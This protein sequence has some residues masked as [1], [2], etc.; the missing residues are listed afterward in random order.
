MRAPETAEYVLPAGIY[1]IGDPCY[2]VGPQHD[3][4]DWLERAYRAGGSEFMSSDFSPV[5]LLADIS[6][7]PV[8]GFGTMCGDGLYMDQHGNRY[9]VDAGLIGLVPV[10]LPDAQ[11]SWGNEAWHVIEFTSEVRCR[12]DENGVIEFMSDAEYVCI[13]TGDE[14]EDEYEDEMEVQR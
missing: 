9:A 3:W 13:N 12:R 7:K 6:G 8:L 5:G 4:M 11:E 10:D 2:S 1:R 14:P